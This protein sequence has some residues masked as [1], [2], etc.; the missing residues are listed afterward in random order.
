MSPGLFSVFKLISTVLRFGCF[1]FLFWFAVSLVSFL[2]LWGRFQVLQL[3]LV[4][5]S[6]AC[7]TAFPD[8]CQDASICLSF[9]FPYMVCW[10]GKIH[11]LTSFILFRNSRSV[12]FF[13]LVRIR[14]SLCILFPSKKKKKKRKKK[15]RKRIHASHFIGRVLIFAHTIWLYGSILISDTIPTGLSLLWILL[16]WGFLI[17]ELI[18]LFIA[19][20]LSSSW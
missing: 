4:S 10:D 3:Q 15:K 20:F 17:W 5:L 11:S 19:D 16:R 2:V 6:S 14:W 13:F 7:S 9:Y 18:F 8:Y 12:F 1:Q